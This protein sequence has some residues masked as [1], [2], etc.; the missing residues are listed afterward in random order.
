MLTQLSKQRATGTEDLVDL[1]GECHERIRRFVALA[2]QAGERQDATADQISQ[3][4]VDVERYFTQ[5]LPL[6][7]ADE[8]QSIEP[9]L[10]GL[11]PAVDEALDVAKRQ[12]RR[13]EPLLK[14]LLRSTRV[15][16]DNP[17]DRTARDDVAT[18]ARALEA[19]FEEHLR[20]EES[21]IFPA[22]RE[23]LSHE[24]QTSIV[25]ELRKR[26]QG[27]PPRPGGHS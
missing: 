22:I 25:D 18:T 2:R 15:L 13:H 19:E 9:R 1:L 6:H 7:V 14:V 11:S 3:A 16:R 23:L 10:C 5:A 12:H 8:E 20:L 4:C 21:T 27:S 26:R 24:T 17:H